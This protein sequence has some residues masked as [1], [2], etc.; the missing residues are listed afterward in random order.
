MYTFEKNYKM[1]AEEL[2]KLFFL[3]LRHTEKKYCTVYATRIIYIGTKASKKLF[4]IFDAA[5]SICLGIPSI[6][7]AM[8]SLDQKSQYGFS[9][10]C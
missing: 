6:S 1:E 7:F 3:L 8:S 10:A 4:C 9:K 5:H 2:V